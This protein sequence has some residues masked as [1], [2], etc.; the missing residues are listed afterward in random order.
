MALQD[1]NKKHNT[2]FGRQIAAFRSALA[3]GVK[4]SLCT[5]PYFCKPEEYSSTGSRARRPAF[6]CPWPHCK[7]LKIVA[8]PMPGHSFETAPLTNH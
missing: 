1:Q 6:D 4:E 2:G 5:A 8:A 3:P 7:S